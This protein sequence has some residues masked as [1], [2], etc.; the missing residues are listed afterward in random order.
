MCSGHNLPD[1]EPAQYQNGN[2]AR[3]HILDMRDIR[4]D[5]KDNA[6]QTR[7]KGLRDRLHAD[8][9]HPGGREQMYP[10]AAF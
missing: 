8:R 10:C 5:L 2:G 7:I 9:T 6:P 4:T 1:A 3:R